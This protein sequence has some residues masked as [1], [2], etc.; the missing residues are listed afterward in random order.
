MNMPYSDYQIV[1]R[2]I[3]QLT[4][5]AHQSEDVP[6]TDLEQ[7][8]DPYGLSTN[9]VQRLFSKSVGVSPKRFQQFLTTNDLQQRLQSSSSLLDLSL[10]TGLSSVSRVHAHFVNFYAMTPNEYRNQGESL[11]LRH[12]FYPSPFGLAHIATTSK[13]ICWL[14]FIDKTQQQQSSDELRAQWINATFVEDNVAH[15][16]TVDSLFQLEGTK[17]LYLHIKGTNFQLKV[18]EA[19]LKIPMGK[20]VSYQTIAQ[21]IERPK[22]SRA[23]GSAIGKNPIGWLIPCH[24]VIRAS[25]VL[26]NYRWGATRKRSL[27]GWEGELG[28]SS[29]C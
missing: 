26:G 10:E 22:A 2:L 29:L 18:W 1:E 16:E 28:S 14:A 6:L 20:C 27:L 21:S 13:G 4:Q 8:G 23:V 12:G 17:P 3:A 5:E 7:L 25:G 15:R 19:L 11:T 24:R 9:Q